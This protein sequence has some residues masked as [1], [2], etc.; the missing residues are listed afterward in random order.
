MKPCPYPVSQL[1][2]HDTPMILIDQVE[3]YDDENIV[4]NINITENSPF[5]YE[6]AVPSYIAVEYMAQ[7]V[8]CYSGVQARN[9]GNEIRIGF[10]LGTRK[11]KLYADEFHVGDNL[12]VKAQILYND[13]EM[14]A[15][16]CHILKKNQIVAKAKLNVYQ[17][18]N[19][20]W[21]G[22]N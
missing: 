21:L 7:T 8:A 16:D 5:S 18:E 22:S 6:G 12:L 4:S 10:L 20:E 9:S 15:F 2:V 11:L 1:L 13:G 17:P 3:G 19:Q 14:A